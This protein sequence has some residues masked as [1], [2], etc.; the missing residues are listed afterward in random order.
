MNLPSI[1]KA[2]TMRGKVID[3]TAAQKRQVATA[4][5]IPTSA[6][7]LETVIIARGI[8]DT[9]LCVIEGRPLPSR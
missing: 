9:Y 4:H 5:A 8:R 3:N 1:D 7:L 2:P 6:D